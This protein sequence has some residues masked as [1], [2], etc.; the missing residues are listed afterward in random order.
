ML[1]RQ[2]DAATAK[3]SQGRPGDQQMGLCQWLDLEAGPELY[4]IA[5]LHAKMVEFSGESNQ[6]VKTKTIGI[7]W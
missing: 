3:K 7:L 1:N 2:L 6:K 5:E 4:T